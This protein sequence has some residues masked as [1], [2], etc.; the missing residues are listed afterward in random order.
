MKKIVLFAVFIVVF[1]GINTVFAQEAAE[2]SGLILNEIMPSN[3]ITLED[4][5]GRHPDWVEIF[6]ASAQAISLDGVCL[7]DKKKELDRYTFPE[8]LTLQPNEYLVVFCSGLKK[9]VDGELHAPFKLS[10]AGEA[11]YLSRDGQIIDSVLFDAME[12][13]TSLCYTG[14]GTYAVSFTPTPGAK[15]QAGR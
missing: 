10:A 4:C 15:N 8:G 9:N 13:D 3:K 7:S 2:K 6:N 12:S 1:C 11:V 5:F 14:E